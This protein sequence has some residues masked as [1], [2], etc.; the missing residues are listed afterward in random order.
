MIIMIMMII[1]IIITVIIVRNNN[2]N[3]NTHNHKLCYSRSRM[4]PGR[5]HRPG[6]RS[7]G[8]LSASQCSCVYSQFLFQSMIIIII[9][10]IIII[11][12]FRF[13]IVQAPDVNL[14]LGVDLA[15]LAACDERAPQG[16]TTDRILKASIKLKDGLTS[17]LALQES[18][19]L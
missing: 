3:N 16:T 18:A 6:S 7:C 15:A 1:I 19:G 17:V 12:V 10:I 8:S 9:I 11:M 5:Q 13:P 14:D 2:S 4:G